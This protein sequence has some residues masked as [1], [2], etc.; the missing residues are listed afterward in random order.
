MLLCN[1]YCLYLPIVTII[2]NSCCYCHHYVIVVVI[3]GVVIVVTTTNNNNGHNILAAGMEWSLRSV[4]NKQKRGGMVRSF[5]I[6][7]S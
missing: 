5:Y 7:F 1:S 3:N 6:L 4:S 2:F